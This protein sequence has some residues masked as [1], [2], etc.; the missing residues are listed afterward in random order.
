LDA[1]I[2]VIADIYKR[3]RELT[4]ATIMV[5]TIAAAIPLSICLV[6]LPRLL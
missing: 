2:V 6:L 3:D 5:S 4:S 1:Q